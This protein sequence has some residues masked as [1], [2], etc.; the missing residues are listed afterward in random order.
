M[1]RCGPSLAKMNQKPAFSIAR[2]VLIGATLNVAACATS[3][4]I[5]PS[6]FLGGE[7]GAECM[8]RVLRTRMP[9]ADPRVRVFQD[10][11]VVYARLEFTFHGE[12]PHLNVVTATKWQ[13]RPTIRPTQ[14]ASPPSRISDR[15]YLYYFQAGDNPPP[16][17]LAETGVISPAVIAEWDRS[18]DAGEMHLWGGLVP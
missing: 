18:C 1:D 11:D 5:K 17:G 13:A 12:R 10:F 2:C 7:A 15:Q 3:P 6:A 8:A 16:K 14:T 4:D 9:D